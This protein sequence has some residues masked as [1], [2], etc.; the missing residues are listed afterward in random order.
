MVIY[1]SKKWVGSLSHFYRSYVMQQILKAVVFMGLYATAVVVVMEDVIKAD[2]KINSGIFS[3]LGIVLSIVLVFRT[4][5]A[6]DRWWEGRKHWGE[7]V[8][9]SRSLAMQ[10]KAII[11][12][13]DHQNQ[14]F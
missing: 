12:P 2:I 8:N 9:H 13:D 1:D 11:P 3:L 4:N 5:S 14:L 6:Y 10:L 7:L